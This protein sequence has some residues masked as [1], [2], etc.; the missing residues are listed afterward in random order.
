[1][2]RISDVTLRRGAR[3]LFEDASMNV[4]PGQKVGLVGANGS[5]KSSLLALVRNELHAD[6]GEVVLPP[7]WVL[8]HVAQETPAIERPALEFAIDG[9]EELRALEA[10]IAEAEGAHAEG[11]AIAELHARYGEIGGYQ[12]RARAQSMLAGLGFNEDAQSRPVATFS[13]GWRMRLNLARALMCR[14]DLLLRE[15]RGA[16]ALER[17]VVARVGVEPVRLHVHDGAGHRVQELAVVG[18]EDHRAGERLE[19]VLEP[20]HGVEVEVVG[21]LVQQQQVRPAGQ[22]AP[23]RS[24]GQLTA[25]ERAQQPVQ[26]GVVAEAQTVQGGQGAFTPPVAAGVLEARLRLGVTAECGLVVGALGHGLLEVGQL[27]FDRDQLTGPGQHVLPEAEA[28][29]PR[30]SLV[31]Q[32]DLGV[33][34]QHELAEVDR[35]LARQHPEQRGLARAVAAGQ[36]HPVVALQLERDAAQE[37]LARDVLAD[38]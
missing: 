36:G 2:L 27:F 33:L 5:G 18:D 29:V 3:V 7:R 8:A 28:E 13:G 25:R 9:D 21:R 1:M 10:S 12:A 20:Q 6:A 35:G 24:A 11:V 19:P 14:S 30:G 34:G 26:I 37:R 38:V 4:H 31:V 17:A 16:L 23:E 22:R 32:G 15:P